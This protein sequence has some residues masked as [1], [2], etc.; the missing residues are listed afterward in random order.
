MK[1]FMLQLLLGLAFM[2]STWAAR[3][4]EDIAYTIEGF[5]IPIKVVVPE[6]GEGPFPV[7]YHVH[8]GGW[9]GGTET[10]VPAP[11]VYA[12]FHFLSDQIGVI[13]VGL[14]YRG[15]IQGDFQDAL[16]DLRASIRWFEL[17]ADE[18]NA[19]LSRVGFSGGSA[20]TPLSAILAQE[21]PASK[22]FVGFFGV[23]DLLNNTESLF[24]DEDARAAYGLGSDEQKHA[25]SVFHNLRTSPPASLLF[26]GGHDILTHPS[27]SLRF[28]KRL[29]EHGAIAE[30][31][32]YP[33][34]NHGY[35]SERYPVEF[36]DTLLRIAELYVEH[37][38]IESETTSRLAANID[39][40]VG[41][42]FPREVIAPADILG[43]WNGRRE[44]YTFIDASTGERSVN[45]NPGH[46][47]TYKIDR[48]TLILTDETGTT[49]FYLQRDGRALCLIVENDVRRTGQRFAFTKQ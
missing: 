7:V 10:S 9:N 21:T 49:E 25:A 38:G 24:P 8:G 20:G 23:Y 13:H 3:E 6:T 4:V 37:L 31:I 19:D 1:N 14:A 48:G 43:T 45:S 41:G 11:S 26:H 44:S 39:A 40:R 33:D 12:G 17:R 35:F 46:Q 36:K 32:I 18:F 22:T 5:E 34:V 28:A 42:Y 2:G 30:A 16:H 15:K 47:F 29:Q 27:Q